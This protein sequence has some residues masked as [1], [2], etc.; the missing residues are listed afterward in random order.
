MNLS[1]PG[2]GFVVV[3][4]LTK[5]NLNLSS[6]RQLSSAAGNPEMSRRTG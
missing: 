2:S 1:S 5:V 6:V 3:V 4:Q